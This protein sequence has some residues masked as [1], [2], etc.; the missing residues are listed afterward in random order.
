MTSRRQNGDVRVTEHA[1]PQQAIDA[2]Y[3][4]RSADTEHAQFIQVSVIAKYTWITYYRPANN[5][6]SLVIDKISQIKVQIVG[7]TGAHWDTRCIG[8][9]PL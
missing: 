6:I 8:T 9:P 1:R 3:T 5:P 7:E 4:Q 2:P